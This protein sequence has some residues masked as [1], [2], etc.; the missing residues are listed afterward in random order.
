METS[1]EMFFQGDQ[2][3]SRVRETLKLYLLFLARAI[4]IRFLSRRRSFIPL[5]QS[6]NNSTLKNLV[7]QNQN[8]TSWRSYSGNVLGASDC[9]FNCSQD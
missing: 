3:S 2:T 4:N 1:T 5:A 8:I 9:I 6:L 7:F